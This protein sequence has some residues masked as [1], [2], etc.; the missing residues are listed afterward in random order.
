MRRAKKSLQ[1]HSREYVSNNQTQTKRATLLSP[2]AC[3]RRQPMLAGPA[4]STQQLASS[5]RA[6]DLGAEAGK[7]ALQ[8]R[9]QGLPAE[10]SKA[11]LPAERRQAHAAARYREYLPT[12]M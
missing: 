10:K 2:Q 9:G 3:H 8:A 12:V 11:R 5:G 7:T 6:C 4:R 1:G